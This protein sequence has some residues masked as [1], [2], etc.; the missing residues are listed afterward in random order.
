MARPAGFDNVLDRCLALRTGE[1]V[2]LLTDAGSDGAVVG[3]LIDGIADRGGV[4]IV[5]TIPTPGLPGSEPP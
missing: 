4:P 5:S 1:Q 2:L 3:G